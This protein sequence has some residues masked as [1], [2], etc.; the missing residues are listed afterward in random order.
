MEHRLGGG[1][2]VA[3]VGWWATWPAEHVNGTIVSDHSGYHFLFEEGFAKTKDSAGLVFPPQAA[4]SI[5]SLMEDPGD[6]DRARLRR[7]IS[8][9]DDEIDAPFSF[10]NDVSH[11]KWLLSTAESYTR[12]GLKLWKNE[13]PDLLMVYIEGVDSA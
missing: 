8:V 10:D 1:R 5:E 3:V 6:I 7:Y 13:R 11:F 9:S 2:K 4:A 12:I